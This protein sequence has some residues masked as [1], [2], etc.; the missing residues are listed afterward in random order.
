MSHAFQP[1]SAAQDWARQD[2]RP[3][4]SLLGAVKKIR[5][6]MLRELASNLHAE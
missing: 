5:E 3:V 4:P 1:A 6:K 2:I